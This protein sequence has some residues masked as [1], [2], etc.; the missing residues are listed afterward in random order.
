MEIAL[1]FLLTIAVAAFI[2]WPF[3]GRV[4]SETPPEVQLSPLE[5][6]KRE[7]YA[8]IKEAEFDYQMGKLTDVDLAALR[9]KYSRQAIAA[10]TAM[11]SARAGAAPRPA[12]HGKG[13]GDRG[14]SRI[15]YCPA[16]GH[17]VAARANFCGGCGR[18]LKVP[19]EVAV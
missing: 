18:S 5:R 16:C 19:S 10:I 9:D 2:A 14:P 3:F 1:A 13:A 6:Q 8:A 11:E 15:A 17:K 7:A 12:R 4:D